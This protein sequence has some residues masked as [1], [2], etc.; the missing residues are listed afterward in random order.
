M[1]VIV[2]SSKPL[3]NHYFDL[4]WSCW[5]MQPVARAP[6]LRRGCVHLVIFGPIK[7]QSV[8]TCYNLLTS[9]RWW[10]KSFNILSSQFTIWPVEIWGPGGETVKPTPTRASGMTTIYNNETHML[11]GIFSHVATLPQQPMKCWLRLWGSK[12]FSAWA[13]L[14]RPIQSGLSPS[15]WPSPDRLSPAFFT[16]ITHG[17]FQK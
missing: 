1:F 17:G 11:R 8:V 12:L 16:G 13:R 6:S 4:F 2:C 7:H 10:F 15:C 9:Q 14:V 5:S 3:R